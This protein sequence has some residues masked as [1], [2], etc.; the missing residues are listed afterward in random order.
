[1][2]TS[3]RGDITSRI[4]E[5]SYSQFSRKEVGTYASWLSNDMSTIQTSTYQRIY[6]VTSGVIG[7]ITSVIALFSF[8]GH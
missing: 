1:M 8:I 2:I 3:I 7:T 6:D 5:T 4:E